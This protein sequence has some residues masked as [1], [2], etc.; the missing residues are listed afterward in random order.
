MSIQALFLSLILSASIFANHHCETEIEGN[1]QMNFNK[2]QI[3]IPGDCK[4]FTVTL[5]HV[6]KLKKDVMGHNWV[7]LEESKLNDVISKAMTAGPKKDYFP[8]KSLF[9]TA[10]KMVG[11][12]EKSQVKVDVTKLNK[13][14]S[15]LYVCTFPGHAALMKG[16]IVFK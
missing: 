15:Y 13:A 6:G 4:E 16:K 14:K 10:A 12:G 11:G 9:V 7:L 5:K 8:E 3:E 1:D 2:A